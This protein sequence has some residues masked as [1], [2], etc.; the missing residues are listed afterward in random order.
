MQQEKWKMKKKY[1]ISCF[2]ESFKARIVLD[3]HLMKFD[4]VGPRKRFIKE[5]I[6][7]FGGNIDDDGFVR[8]FG[9]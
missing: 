2:D 9:H 7:F 4:T 1:E 8:C 5:M 3:V 6:D